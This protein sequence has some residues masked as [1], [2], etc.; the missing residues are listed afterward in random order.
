[1]AQESAKSAGDLAKAA[2]QQFKRRDSNRFESIL[3]DS[4]ER[5]IDNT[6]QS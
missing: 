2:D 1:M 3:L 4:G 6:G 5:E